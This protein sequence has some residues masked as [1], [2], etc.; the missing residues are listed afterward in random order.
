MKISDPLVVSDLLSLSKD[1]AKLPSYFLETLIQLQ[2]VDLSAKQLEIVGS[3]FDVY[4]FIK[5]KRSPSYLHR[6]IFA[7][8]IKLFKSTG[9]SFRRKHEY[10]LAVDIYR[11]GLNYAPNA[12]ILHKRIIDSYY[13]LGKLDDIKE[14]YL[15]AKLELNDS[16]REY[17][18]TYI[19]TYQIDQ[20]TSSLARL[21]ITNNLIVR[22]DQIRESMEW[23]PS[24]FQTLGWLYVQQYYW[25]KQSS[26][27]SSLG[28]FRQSI[29]SIVSFFRNENNTPY[30]RQQRTI[31]RPSPYKVN[32]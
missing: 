24:F 1:A 12:T 31:T 23:E 10:G 11:L 21:S 22:L 9:D 4:K 20:E 29:N 16:Q 19:D 27:T 8:F 3:S 5:D 6:K 7:N 26:E 32:R 28:V 2:K 14:H 25:Q 13:I 30:S 18:Q 17:L 15:E